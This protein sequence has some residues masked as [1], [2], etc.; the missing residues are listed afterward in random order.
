M[1][2]AAGGGGTLDTDPTIVVAVTTG[3]Y[4]VPCKDFKRKPN[5]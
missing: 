4:E 1:S 2:A 5:S 3:I